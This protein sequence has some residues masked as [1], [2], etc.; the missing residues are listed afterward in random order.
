MRKGAFDVH[1]PGSC[2]ESRAQD[3]VWGDDGFV[4]KLCDIVCL[5]RYIRGDA[6]KG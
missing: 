1:R 5:S 2:T 4:N 6:L 3:L